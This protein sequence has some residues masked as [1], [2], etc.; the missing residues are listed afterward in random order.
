[1]Y[2]HQY[3]QADTEAVRATYGILAD[4]V[5]SISPG[6]ASAGVL[7]CR[8]LVQGLATI[9][10]NGRLAPS[11]PTDVAIAVRILVRGL[12]EDAAEERRL[13]AT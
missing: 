8:S 3:G 5:A 11:G 13:Y 6:N 12:A 1:M 9:V 7:A 4:R 2:S 10:L